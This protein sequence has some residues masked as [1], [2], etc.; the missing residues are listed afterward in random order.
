MG[1]RALVGLLG[2]VL[3]N[4]ACGDSTSSD[5]KDA[6]QADTPADAQHGT[7]TEV[8]PDTSP[9][10]GLDAFEDAPVTASLDAPV[11][12]SL[13]APVTASLDAPVTAFLDA[14]VTAFLDAPVTAS[15]DAPVTASLDASVDGLS[16]APHMTVCNGSCVDPNT[17][18]DNCGT[19][20]VACGASEVCYLGQCNPTCPDGTTQCGGGCT[21]LQSDPNHCGDCTAVDA[22][23]VVCDSNQVCNLGQCAASCDA[24]LVSCQ[25]R[26]IDPMT[27][28]IFCGASASCTLVDGGTPGTTCAPGQVCS[29]GVCR[30]GCDVGQTRCSDSLCHNLMTEDANC[31][32]CDSQCAS[33][34]QCISGVCTC[35]VPGTCP[36]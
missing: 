12:A 21:D 4:I 27:N 31:G 3:T 19:C 7:D 9:P 8:V 28:P 35:I 25:G 10:V 33:D 26:C 30:N 22:G 20:A 34:K 6:N 14:P 23:S 24:T 1:A 13:D 32:W 36:L 29:G 18:H 15:L 2:L 5:K 16:C 17:D 11:T